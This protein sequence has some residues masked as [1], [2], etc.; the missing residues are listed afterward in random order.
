[1]D[2]TALP[3]PISQYIHSI[4]HPVLL[5]KTSILASQQNNLE[6]RKYSFFFLHF[7]PSNFPKLHEGMH[8]SLKINDTSS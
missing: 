3:D 2:I 8:V 6:I 1:M 4:D 7:F 5:N